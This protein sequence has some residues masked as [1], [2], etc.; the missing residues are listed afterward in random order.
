MIVLGLMILLGAIV[1]FCM[2]STMGDSN[3]IKV[4]LTK[5][6]QETISF[7]NPE[8]DDGEEAYTVSLRS[9]DAGECTVYF[10]FSEN[11]RST[12]RDDIFAK[13]IVGGETVCDRSLAELFD[14][15]AIGFDCTLDKKEYK[16]VTV[17]YY[18]A[19]GSSANSIDSE[20]DFDINIMANN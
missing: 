19:D 14:G 16:E 10:T 1:S 3:N 17:V 2:L 7:T 13:V 9:K 18:F 5:G 4:E 8:L 20:I 12:L 15:N 11:K 6:K